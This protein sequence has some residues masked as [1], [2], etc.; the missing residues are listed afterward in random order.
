MRYENS[1]IKKI[2]YLISISKKARVRRRV[3]KRFGNIILTRY[4]MVRLSGFNLVVEERE[5]ENGGH[6]QAPRMNERTISSNQYHNFEKI[7]Y[8]KEIIM[9][10]FSKRYYTLIY[11]QFFIFFQYFSFSSH[12]Y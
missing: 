5:S 2:R 4:K 8:I 11:M 3:R 10:K 6:H 7:K 9:S 12:N 1:K